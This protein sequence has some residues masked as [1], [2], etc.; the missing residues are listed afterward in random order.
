MVFLQINQSIN[1]KVTQYCYLTISA[2]MNF[3]KGCP[4]ILGMGG[5]GSHLLNYYFT[6]GFSFTAGCA[7]SA[8]GKLLIMTAY[9][10]VNDHPIS[11]TLGITYC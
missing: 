1:Q 9:G 7:F 6:V 5:W 11:P 2:T 8:P 10:L 4:E 3:K